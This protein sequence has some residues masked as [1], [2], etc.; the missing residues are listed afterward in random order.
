MTTEV[1]KDQKEIRTDFFFL[2]LHTIYTYYIEK[3]NS[4]GSYQLEKKIGRKTA[5]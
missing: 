5:L 3:Y 4:T 2:I 1:V